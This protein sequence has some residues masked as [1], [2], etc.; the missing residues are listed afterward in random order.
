MTTRPGSRDPRYRPSSRRPSA[1]PDA[2]TV[3]HWAQLA[4][5]PS[6]QWQARAVR[7]VAVAADVVRSREGVLR[8]TCDRHLLAWLR[9]GA[10]PVG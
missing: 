8:S 4:E 1:P 9:T 5:F 2:D 6:C 7:C 3:A 10:R